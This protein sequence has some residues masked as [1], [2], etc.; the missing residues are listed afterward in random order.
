MS[1]ELRDTSAVLAG[2]VT[3]EEVEAFVAWLRATPDAS[4]DLSDCT[5]MHTGVLQALLIFR[6]KVTAEPAEYFLARHVLPLLSPA[7]EF[8]DNGDAGR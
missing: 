7:E 3:I 5:H 8:D 6:P 1:V 2:V 4:V